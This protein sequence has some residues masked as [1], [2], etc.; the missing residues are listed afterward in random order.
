[1]QK[2]CSSS[3]VSSLSFFVERSVQ[4]TQQ[5]ALPVWRRLNAR[6][7]GED[8]FVRRPIGQSKRRADAIA[9]STV[10]NALQPVPAGV[11]GPGNSTVCRFCCVPERST[12]HTKQ[13][14]CFPGGT[15]PGQDAS[16][17]KQKAWFVCEH[18]HAG[19]VAVSVCQN[20]DRAGWQYRPG[21]HWIVR[22][23][24]PWWSTD[25]GGARRRLRPRGSG[26][27]ATP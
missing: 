17:R 4:P 13:P 11:T 26:H 25:D 5:S 1:M 2:G 22:L 7:W 12:G 9:R 23:R 6:P 3:A 18:D 27:P 24:R 15:R 16:L 21:A 10:V 20:T 14:R 8:S 19:T